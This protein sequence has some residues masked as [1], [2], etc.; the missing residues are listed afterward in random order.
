M[1]F[2]KLWSAVILLF[3]LSACIIP[4]EKIIGEEQAEPADSG[5]KSVIEKVFSPKDSEEKDNTIVSAD[6]FYAADLALFSGDV[7]K[8]LEEYQN[9][10]SK[11]GENE[12]ARALYGLGR[13]YALG[14]EYFPAIDAFNRVLGQYEESEYTAFAYYQ[15][16][17]VYEEIG[18]LQQAINAFS[19]YIQ[20]R[21]EL[22]NRR[23][24]NVLAISL[25]RRAIST[26]P[27]S[28]TNPRFPL[29]LNICLTR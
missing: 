1:N 8:A 25:C 16:G 28:A 21:P 22:L 27:S 6:P 2:K 15:L 4:F 7:E 26:R 12:Q 5:I 11:V 14:K 29:I 3:F 23:Y 10:F 18:E 24:T 20:L 13:A 9:A 19:R 17:Q